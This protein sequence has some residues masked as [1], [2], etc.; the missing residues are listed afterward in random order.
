MNDA[1]IDAELKALEK[2]KAK[3]KRLIALRDE[4][5]GLEDGHIA[6]SKSKIAMAKI[7]E[8]VCTRYGIGM[9]LLRSRNRQEEVATPRQVF[10]YL[11]REQAIPFKSVGRFVGRD[12][13][14][15]VH[16][17]RCVRNRIDIDPEFATVVSELSQACKAKL[18]A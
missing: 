15:A 7:S 14:T 6:V 4:V 5:A 12:H 1:A 2:R 3:L 11:C 10:F 8:E 18:A 17:C 13:T 9:D 16:G